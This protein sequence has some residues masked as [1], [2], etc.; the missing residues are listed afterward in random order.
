[1]S[2]DFEVL[3]G[4][5]V[6]VELG[7]RKVKVEPMP[8]DKQIDAIEAYT[9]A[10]GGG[11]RAAMLAM[12]DIL[13][14]ACDVSASEVKDGSTLPQIMK[15]FTAVWKQNGFDFLLEEMGKLTQAVKAG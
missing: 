9:K 10:A 5:P 1:M 11:A 12:V 6:E 8:L 4:K 14:L 7:G 13:A 15:A 3:I 2:G